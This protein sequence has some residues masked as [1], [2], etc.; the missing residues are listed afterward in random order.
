MIYY[1]EESITINNGSAKKKKWKGIGNIFNRK[2]KQIIKTIL[3]ESD[4][5]A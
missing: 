3:F 4:H 2:Q 1:R 5:I